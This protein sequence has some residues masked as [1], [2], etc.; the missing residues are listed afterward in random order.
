MLSSFNNNGASC[1]VCVSLSN[2]V[3]RRMS[4]DEVNPAAVPQPVEDV[5]GDGRWLS[6]VCS[7]LWVLI[8]YDFKCESTCCPSDQL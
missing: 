8:N 3:S 4:G 6:Q 2:G 7:V 1:S 5:H